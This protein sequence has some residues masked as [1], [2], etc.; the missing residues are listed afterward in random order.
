MASYHT[1]HDDRDQRIR[2][3]EAENA[4]LRHNTYLQML[5]SA[6]L[7]HAIDH[8]PAGRYVLVFADVDQMK[9]INTATGSHDATDRHLAAGLKVRDNEL[10][11]QLR[12][13][14]IAFIL[15][16]ATN[17]PAFIARIGAQLRRQRLDPAARRSL[18]LATGRPHITVTA[19]WRAGVCPREMRAVLDELSIEV[20]AMKAARDAVGPRC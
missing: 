9:A 2:A 16:E 19:A 10:A 6:G 11:G 8:L 15:E 12:G 20:L 18:L 7:L 13:D 14:E 5:N 1:Y 3:L 17:A 4:R